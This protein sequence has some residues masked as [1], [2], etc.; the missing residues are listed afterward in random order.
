MKSRFR[1][2]VSKAASLSGIS[3]ETLVAHGRF[4]AAT[5]CNAQGTGCKVGGCPNGVW[6]VLTY[7][8]RA[9]DLTSSDGFTVGTSGATVS[10]LDISG[11]LLKTPARRIHP[12]RNR[13]FR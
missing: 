8:E 6:Y 12:A 9:V 11:N 13:N 4:W 2:I 10:I 3:T 7:D 5:G 1:K